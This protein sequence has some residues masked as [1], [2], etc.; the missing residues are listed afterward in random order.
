MDVLCDP[1]LYA[2]YSKEVSDILEE[3]AELEKN[4]VKIKNI[5]FT[6]LNI[7]VSHRFNNIK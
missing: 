3:H 5:L 7:Y 6:S 2:R 4:L 1:N